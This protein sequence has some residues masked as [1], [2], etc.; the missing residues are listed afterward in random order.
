MKKLH[1]GRVLIILL[2]VSTC[3][4]GFIP[5]GKADTA[6]SAITKFIDPEDMVQG[7]YYF[8][9]DHGSGA[10]VAQFDRYENGTIYN[11]YSITPQQSLFSHNGSCTVYDA[12]N[13]Q[14]AS[15]VEIIHLIRCIIAGIYIP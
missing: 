6:K 4:L 7:G 13:I 11:T 5:S 1:I 10:M 3:S 8:F 15:V 12:G 2:L 9:W 14:L